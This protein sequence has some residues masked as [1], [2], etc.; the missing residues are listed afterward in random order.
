MRR[1]GMQNWWCSLVTQF[2]TA[3]QLVPVKK[4]WPA[5]REMQ[6][7]AAMLRGF[8]IAGSQIRELCDLQYPKPFSIGWD[9]DRFSVNQMLALATSEMERRNFANEAETSWKETR[10]A[11]TAAARKVA[12]HAKNRPSRASP[13]VDR[14]PSHVV[15]PPGVRFCI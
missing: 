7:G 5:M 3:K 10:K 2:V 12:Q 9:H 4:F 15:A 1:I 6:R 14:M 11:F 13:F 8:Q